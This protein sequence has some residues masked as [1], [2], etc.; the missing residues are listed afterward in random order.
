MIDLLDTIRRGYER[1]DEELPALSLYGWAMQHLDHD[2]EDW[3][4]SRIHLSDY[5]YAL[6]PIEGG[7]DRQLYHRLRGDRRKD[8]TLW[9]RLMWDQGFAM[10]VRVSWLMASG[11]PTPWVVDAVEKDLTGYLPNG[12]TG[13]CDLVLAGAGQVMGVEF[14]TQRGRAFQY[15][16]GP[17]DSHTMQSEA[18]AYALQTMYPKAEVEHRLVYLDREGQNEPRVF[19]TMMGPEVFLRVED[20][21]AYVHQIANDLSAENAPDDLDPKISVREN[22][23]PDSIYLEQPWVCD[24]CDFQDVVCPGA[25]P[26]HLR[27]LGIVAKGDVD[28]PRV[29]HGETPEDR[30]EIRRAIKAAAAAGNLSTK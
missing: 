3:D 11:L 27:D 6:D 8:P 24:Y 9:M 29:T 4:E 18:E 7:C 22:K 19:A 21:S 30:N 25:L 28:D 26:P 2:P 5:R 20:A 16:D 13:S 23:G 14:K 15:M 12:D 17:K 10:Q 1:R